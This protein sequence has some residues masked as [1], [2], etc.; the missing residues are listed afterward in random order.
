V[1]PWETGIEHNRSP[2]CAPCRFSLIGVVV[3]CPQSSRR[4]RNR[5]LARMT[6]PMAQ[7]PP[8]ATASTNHARQQVQISRALPIYIYM[9]VFVCV[10]IFQ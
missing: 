6:P 1:E 7:P 10:R 9:H 2:L 5:A 4:R 3:F 8:F